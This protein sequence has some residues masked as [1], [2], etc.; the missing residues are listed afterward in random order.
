MDR[1]D[2]IVIGGSAGAL[3]PLRK[4]V[5]ELPSGLA[6]KLFVVIH[7]PAHSGDM[8]GICI[9][10]VQAPADAAVSDMP[11]SAIRNASV[12]HIVPA[13]QLAEIIQRVGGQ[14]A[15]PSQEI[16]AELLLEAQITKAGGTSVDL[17]TSLSELTPF[18][19]NQQPTR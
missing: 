6:A 11:E 8:L 4:I 1:H 2:I 17:Q 12:D 5:T 19:R 9:A 3:D 10:I 7:R 13:Q 18:I 14:P 16:P 15:G